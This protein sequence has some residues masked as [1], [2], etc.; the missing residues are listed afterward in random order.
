MHKLIYIPAVALFFFR[1]AFAYGV[2]PT[3]SCPTS[4]PNYP[5]VEV[6]Q[7]P[8]NANYYNVQSDSDNNTVI[9]L[10][11]PATSQIE[12]L[13]TSKLIMASQLSPA[14]NQAIFMYQGQSV[15][16]YYC[17]YTSSSYTLSTESPL[18]Q[19]ANPSEAAYY[20]ISVKVNKSGTNK[21]NYQ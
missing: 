4:Y 6:T 8:N 13:N 10:I 21:H 17:A 16:I 14:E 9:G 15:A 1:S 5:L 12:A 2:T 7:I 3:L 19:N 11:V 18:Q 20:Y